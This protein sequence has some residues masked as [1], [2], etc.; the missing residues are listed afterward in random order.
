METIFIIG[1]IGMVYFGIMVALA[2]LLNDNNGYT[3]LWGL[4]LPLVIIIGTFFL[5]KIWLTNLLRF[6]KHN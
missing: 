1:I 5:M 4:W 2:E 6:A 3:L